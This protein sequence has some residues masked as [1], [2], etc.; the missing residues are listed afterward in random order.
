M[1]I[2][3]ERAEDMK[4]N[5]T[6]N[7]IYSSHMADAGSDHSEMEKSYYL[8]ARENKFVEYL[9]KALDMIEEG[10]FGVCKECSE[11]IAKERLFEV[12]HTTSCFTCKTKVK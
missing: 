9:N 5:N 11:L 4:S 7:A 8:I 10:R 12:P 2:A 6:H 3:R 1:N